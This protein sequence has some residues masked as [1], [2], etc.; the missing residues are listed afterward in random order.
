[1]PRT[2]FLPSLYRAMMSVTG[3][4]GMRTLSR[5]NRSMYPGG[6]T[7]RLTT[8]SEFYVPP[9]PHFFGYVVGHEEH[10]TRLIAERVEEGDVCIDVG[11]NIGYFSVMLAA[12]CG[13]SGQVLAY[14]PEPGNFA[15]L[16]EN[17]RIAGQRGLTIT[18]T[19]AAVSD[20]SGE[21]ELV[22]GEESTLHEV[23]PLGQGTRP[24]ETVR[25]VSLA[26]DLAARGFDGL[27]KLIKV[28]VEGHEAAVLS[29]CVPLFTSGRVHAAVVEVTPGESAAEIAEILRRC[30]ASVR[31]WVEN[32]WVDIAVDEIPWRTDVLATF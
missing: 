26:D 17:A 6:Q 12:R 16:S 2:T 21:L 31:C 15:V 18:P 10:I 25:C 20:R 23:R 9:D 11:A 13:R 8:G 7:I 29:A 14:E 24:G 32:R 3:K 19:C 5:I 1:M 4:R 30:D 22:R 28:D 27:I